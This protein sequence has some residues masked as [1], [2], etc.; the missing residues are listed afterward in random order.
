MKEYLLDPINYKKRCKQLASSWDNPKRR[1]DHSKLFSS[2]KW[3]NDGHRN[4][5]KKEI[6]EGYK[7]GRLL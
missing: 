5:R 3:C 4:Y 7:P 1:E 2:L 6:P